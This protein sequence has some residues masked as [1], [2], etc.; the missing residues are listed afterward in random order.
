M[1]PIR[2][3]IWNEFVHERKKPEV[4]AIYPDGIHS[5]IAAAL[6]EHLGE[7][8][9]VTTATLDQSDQ[10]LPR[11]RLEDTDVLFWWGH[12]AHGEVT[13]ALADRVVQRVHEGMGLIVLHSGHDSKPFKRLMGT[14]C[15]L[16]WREAGERERLWIIDAG[17]PIVEGLET[18]CWELPTT[19]MYGEPFGIPTPDQLIMI[20]WFAGGEV[21]RSACTWRRGKGSVFYF[22]PG[23]ETYPIYHDERVRRVLA[24]AARWAAPRGIPYALECRNAPARQ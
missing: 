18:D 17:H 5:V 16:Q 2:I 11:K 6:S 20:S 12:A 1:A 3:T 13:D 21:F 10:G 24:N 23:H 19:E 15:Q 4:Q 14:P 22:R 7:Q 8:A 9:H